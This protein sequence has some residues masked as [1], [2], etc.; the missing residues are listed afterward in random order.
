MTQCWPARL[1]PLGCS[2]STGWLLC[3]SILGVNQAPPAAAAPK[4]SVPSG[5]AAARPALS[6]S[7]SELLNLGPANSWKALRSRP[8][9]DAAGT[10]AVLARLPPVHSGGLR[11]VHLVPVGSSSWTRTWDFQHLYH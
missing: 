8:Q 5:A 10:A 11:Q 2:V 1:A 4:E 3:G 6:G 7:R 9:A